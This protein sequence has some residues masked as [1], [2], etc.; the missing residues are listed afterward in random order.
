MITG[1]SFWLSVP[2]LVASLHFDYRVPAAT[3]FPYSI[4]K[5]YVINP[6]RKQI[7][8]PLT[9]NANVKIEETHRNA[10]NYLSA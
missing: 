2:V 10:Q 3:W 1:L 4:E 6:N 9:F 7:N 5:Q 8:K